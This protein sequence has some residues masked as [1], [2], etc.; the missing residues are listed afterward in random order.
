MPEISVIIP[1]YN[2]EKYLPAALDSVLAQSFTDF[3]V[4]CV[5]DGS[6]DSSPAILDAYAAKDSRI[7][8]IHRK[9]GGGSASRNTGLD[10]AAGKYIAFMDND[11]LYHPDCLKILLSGFQKYPKAWISTGTVQ[12]FNDGTEIVFPETKKIKRTVYS[13]PFFAKFLFKRHIPMFMWLKL[14]RRDCFKN[15]RFIT[16]LPAT[17]D[18][19]L[20]MEILLQD[21]PLVCS[22]AITYLY[23]WHPAQ[24]SL[25]P[26]SDKRITEFADAARAIYKLAQKQSFL[27]RLILEREAAKSVYSTLALSKDL[28]DEQ[29]RLRKQAFIELIDEKIITP[30]RLSHRRYHEILK[31]VS[32]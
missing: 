25:K 13:R 15:T 19:L 2:A 20:N 17:N 26:L 6:T 27:K 18:I 3:E 8:V 16:A 1:V 4:L 28:T 14:Y 11:D 5:N 24:Q 29:K 9:N 23:R 30:F 7:R 12:G 31:I 22:N 21:K 10:A 32:D